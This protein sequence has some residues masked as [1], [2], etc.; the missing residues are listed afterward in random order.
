MPDRV[1]VRRGLG[2]GG[3]RAQSNAVAEAMAERLKVDKSDLLDRDADSMAVRLALAETHIVAETKD[4][5][6]QVR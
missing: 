3:C 1:R 4:F 5:L 2:R 6:A